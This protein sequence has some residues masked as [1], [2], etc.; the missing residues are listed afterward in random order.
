M[1]PI[2]PTTGGGGF[3]Y[4]NINSLTLNGTGN[5]I[6]ANGI[7]SAELKEDSVKDANGGSGGYIYINTQNDY[8]KN[9]VIEAGAI[10]SAHGGYGKNKGFGGSGGVVVFGKQ[11]RGSTFDV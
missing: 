11:F 6:Q 3:I 1:N 10:I 7:P 5:Q 4:L 8:H 9:N 2:D